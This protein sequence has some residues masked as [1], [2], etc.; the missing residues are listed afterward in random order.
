M[1][2]VY[3]ISVKNP[4]LKLYV[5][6]QL[7]QINTILILKMLHTKKYTDNMIHNSTATKN[8]SMSIE[9]SSCQIEDEFRSTST[10]CS[11]SAD[12]PSSCYKEKYMNDKLMRSLSHNDDVVYKT[13]EEA[14][15]LLW[16]NIDKGLHTPSIGRTNSGRKRR[17]SYHSDIKA[18][19][20]S[21]R[22][23]SH[24]PIDTANSNLSTSNNRRDS[25]C[26]DVDDKHRSSLP[27]RQR[28][29]S[30]LQ[31]WRATPLFTS[32]NLHR[33]SH[34]ETTP[35]CPSRKPSDDTSSGEPMSKN[36]ATS[37]TT[38]HVTVTMTIAVAGALCLTIALASKSWFISILGAIVVVI[39][40]LSMLI[41]ILW[42]SH[43]AQQQ[44]LLTSFA[45]SSVIE[46]SSQQM[47][48][49]ESKT[50]SSNC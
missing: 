41:G 37:Q 26:L 3:L 20:V 13:I 34:T 22:R 50:T 19:G 44:Q 10:N 14:H 8:V 6:R 39:G 40:G 9:L 45:L 5:H 1:S 7:K 29:Q 47:R 30:T 42:L 27:H 48:G 32:S 24:Y 17:A 11:Y 18:G 16:D 23:L 15:A 38:K 28:R 21:G 33:L 25:Y 49:E 2:F 12:A 35:S 4:S 31:Y 36:T 46:D 43:Q